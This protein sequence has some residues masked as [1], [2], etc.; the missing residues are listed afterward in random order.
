MDLENEQSWGDG[1]VEQPSDSVSEFSDGTS[2]YE[3]AP[4]VLLP[5]RQHSVRSTRGVPPVRYGDFDYSLYSH[6]QK[7]LDEPSSYEEAMASPNRLKWQAAM[8]AEYDSLLSNGVWRLVERPQNRNVVKS[9][10]V[11]KVKQD[12]SGNFEKFK[13]RL[14]ARG[15]SQKPGV[16]FDKTF[17]PVVRHS[18][19]RILFNLANELDM[20]VDHI[21]VT[22]AFLHGELKEEIYME[23][24]LG[25]ISDDH[26]VCLLQ[27][28]IYG[29]KQ[30]SRV[31]N[32]TVND[33]LVGNGYS[34]TKCEPCVYVKRDK[35]TSNNITILALYVDD[36]FLFGNDHV[37]KQELFN[38]LSSKFNVKNLGPI[39][40]CLGINVVRD[41][42]K[43]TLMLS[44]K[45]YIKRLLGR[46][47]LSECK[48]VSTPM[49]V[50]EKFY[51]PKDNICE[52]E[53]NF[54]EL[55]GSLMY[56]SVCTRP[57]I[58]YS[59]SVLSQFNNCY[60]RTHWLAG[61]RILRYLARTVDYGLIFHKCKNFNL[62]VFADA[63]WAN[64]PNDR[65][66][67]TGFV[68]K[69]GSN[70]INWE[71][72]KQRCVAMSSTEA[73]YL[74][75]SDACKDIMFTRHFWLEIMNTNVHCKIFND[76]QSAQKLLL[77]KE[78][79]KRTKHID[80]RYHFIKDLVCKNYVSV[81]YMS[82]SEMI[83][84]ILTKALSSCKHNEFM[85]QLNVER[86]STS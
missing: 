46:F 9:K 47:G 24:P 12:A 81:S 30:A 59:C 4:D 68:L 34:Q 3:Q 69:L 33:L 22:T 67:Y 74:A 20:D 61:K 7:I 38:I 40:S 21:D 39:K 54:R 82:T 70:T 72:R 25:F 49:Q 66:S 5:S 60:D 80:V 31:W 2:D 84:D 77:S 85:Y 43:G 48:S 51:I 86:D 73:E 19:M 53:Y 1:R 41:R 8:Q 29:L 64:D 32:E 44:Q 56:L 45:D 42:E 50:N 16:D 14:V 28:S 55:I 35:T 75:I 57:D 65:K 11:Y 23:P 36:F 71:S 63:D 78:C 18:T 17:S 15:F 6:G 26:K 37:E 52:T 76:N 83:A 10:W 27:K 79:H 58:T 13:A 62:Q